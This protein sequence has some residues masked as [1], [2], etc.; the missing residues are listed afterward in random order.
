VLPRAAGIT[1]WAPGA[2][3]SGPVLAATSLSPA[4]HDNPIERER[5]LASYVALVRGIARKK[6]SL[7][8][9]SYERVAVMV[10][11]SL[12]R[13][14]SPQ[15]TWRMRRALAHIGRPVIGDQRFG[16]AATNRHFAEKYGL[17]RVFLH[18]TR[19]EWTRP[20]HPLLAVACPLPDEL[21]AITGQFGEVAVDVVKEAMIG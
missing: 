11:H 18:C 17:D 1:L 4:P 20:P 3:E 13:L 9:T 21:I 10:G 6:G 7:G 19:L 2:D 8:S 5:A 12:L 16:D 15:P 14:S